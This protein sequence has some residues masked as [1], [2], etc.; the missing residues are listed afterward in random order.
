M[1]Q[2][3]EEQ[4]AAYMGAGGGA[5]NGWLAGVDEAGRGPLAGPVVAAAVILPAKLDLAELRD[6]KLL[7]PRQRDRLFDVIVHGARAVAVG[8]MP[9]RAI[10]RF[11]ILGA[12]TRAMAKAVRRL[13][14]EPAIVLI[15]GN[16]AAPQIHLPQRCIVKGDRY[17]ASIA[18]ASIVAKVSRDRIMQSLDRRFPGYGFARHK[19]YPTPQHY[20]ALQRLGPCALHRMTFRGVAASCEQDG[21][22][23]R[24]AGP[25]AAWELGRGRSRPLAQTSRRARH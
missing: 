17:S 14:L 1:R 16:Q 7:T 22:E 23:M 9:A 3:D 10:E 8:M 2:F 6:S 12:T 15:D 11:N 13:R 25:Q 24:D 20:A 18:A 19:G 21:E 5:L 4:L